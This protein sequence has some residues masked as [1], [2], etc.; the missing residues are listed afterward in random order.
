MKLPAIHIG[1]SSFRL[2]ASGFDLIIRSGEDHLD[3]SNSGLQRQKI[4]LDREVFANGV[5]RPAV[6][7][8]S[9]LIIPFARPEN[10]MKSNEKCGGH[11]GCHRRDCGKLKRNSSIHL[12]RSIGGVLSEIQLKRVVLPRP[13]NDGVL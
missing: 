11:N 2:T 1:Q 3:R 13:F 4:I 8:V 7:L 9:E 6:K 10:V 5:P 12:Y